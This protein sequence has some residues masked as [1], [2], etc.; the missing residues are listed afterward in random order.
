[1]KFF[2]C[3]LLLASSVCS[4]R[5]APNQIKF[6]SIRKYSTYIRLNSNDDNNYNYNKNQIIQAVSNNNKAVDLS[7]LDNNA[8]TDNV[9]LD[10]KAAEQNLYSVL[11]SATLSDNNKVLN[12]GPNSFKLKSI[13]I[14]PSWPLLY[15]RIKHNLHEY[16]FDRILITG[17][18]G[19]GKSMF[20]YYYMW[21]AIT[22][23]NVTSFLYQTQVE[24]DVVR[25]YSAT[26]VSLYNSKNIFDC[27]TGLPFFAD[28]VPPPEPYSYAEPA[29]KPVRWSAYTIIFSS[30]DKRRYKELMKD[31]DSVQYILEPWTEEEIFEAWRLVPSFNQVPKDI[32][33]AQYAIYGGVPRFVFDR[34]AEGEGPM[35]HALSVKGEEAAQ[36]MFTIHTRVDNGDREMQT[37]FQ[38][39]TKPPSSAT[40]QLADFEIFVPASPFVVREVSLA[41]P[42]IMMGRF[43]EAM[44][45]KPAG[46]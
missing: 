3:I 37:L 10:P 44:R 43:W 20:S 34:A 40:I 16:E 2:V 41:Y 18:P 29:L 19:I 27:P 12:F 25:H 42:D 28:I 14:H 38:M 26:S 5:L 13:Y 46:V 4:Y 39:R 35:R 31:M 24:V 30:P 21:R 23:E 7:L 36:N 9:V 8:Q 6:S 11:A 17:S 45:H 33:S 22:Q 32:V 1:M 15:E